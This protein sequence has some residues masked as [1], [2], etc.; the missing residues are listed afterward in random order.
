VGK[1]LGYEEDFINEKGSWRFIVGYRN[2]LNEHTP[3]YRNFEPDETLHWEQ[4][5]SV[6]EGDIHTRKTFKGLKSK[7]VAAV[8]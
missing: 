6:T 4:K 7:L 8:R 2:H 1:M 3:W 5:Q